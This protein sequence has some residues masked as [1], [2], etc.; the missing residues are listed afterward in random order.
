[1]KVYGDNVMK[2]RQGLA[3]D[4]VL[5]VPQFSSIESRKDINLSVDFGKGVLLSI[6]IISANMK[7]I[8]EWKL[9]QTI[10]MLGGMGIIHRFNTIAEQAMQYTKATSGFPELV[11][12]IGISI[13]AKDE[14]YDRADEL[15]G[16]YG[17]NIC[18][19]DIANGFS[20]LAGEITK[21]VHNTFPDVLLIS[22]NVATL[23]GAK[24]LYECGAD[25]IKV[26]IGSGSICSTRV[27]TGNGIP[28]ITALNDVHE[29]RQAKKLELKQY[30]FKMIA[31]G[32]AKNP[33]DITKCLCFGDGVMLGNLLSGTD[34]TPTETIVIDGVNYKEY[35]G[36]STLKTRNVEGVKSLVKAKGPLKN[37]I[38]QICDGIRSGCSYQGVDNLEDLKDNPEFIQITSA[39][40]NESKPHSVMVVDT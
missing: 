29:W 24:Y 38:E 12:K 33:G 39:G 22:G 18:V 7:S 40:W 20:S 30:P 16:K 2:I 9:A 34:E 6:P 36:S 14:D 4:D 15:L 32:G 27:M 17:C 25:V 23:N 35:N 5:L 28:T 13:G 26:N 31:D 37:I 3:L 11:N 10:A 19:V 1:M 21:Y 8:T